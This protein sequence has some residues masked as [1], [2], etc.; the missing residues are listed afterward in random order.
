MH[1]Y[2]HGDVCV[3]VCERER[4]SANDRDMHS[5]KFPC[6]NKDVRKNKTVHD[7]SVRYSNTDEGISSS[8][9]Y[10]RN[11]KRGKKRGGDQTD[12]FRY[13]NSVIRMNLLLRKSKKNGEIEWL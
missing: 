4:E 1:E 6:F 3:C 7:E 8:G 12:M 9:W 2:I 11:K 5:H 13:T 10:L